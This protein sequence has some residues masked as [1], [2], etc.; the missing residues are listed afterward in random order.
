M[1]LFTD[2]PIPAGTLIVEYTGKATTWSQVKNDWQNVY[3][4]FVSDDYVIDAKNYPES[5]ARYANDAAGLTFVK[6]MVNNAEFTNIDN[7][8]FIRA[9][10]D[11]PAGN[12]ILVGYGA[13]YWEVLR[14]NSI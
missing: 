1:G 13:A 8:I 11:I 5:Y 4:Y 9:I 7:R 14:K 12:E 6:G 2:D 3:I 10:T